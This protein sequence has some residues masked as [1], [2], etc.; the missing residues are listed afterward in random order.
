MEGPFHGDQLKYIEN[1]E[2]VGFHFTPLSLKIKIASILNKNVINL[3]D[4]KYDHMT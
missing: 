2:I 1:H 4:K 3:S